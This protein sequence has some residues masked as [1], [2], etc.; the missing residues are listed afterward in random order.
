M[1]SKHTKEHQKCLY[2]PVKNHS[3][4]QCRY[5]PQRLSTS[6]SVKMLFFFR[7]NEDTYL[8]TCCYCTKTNRINLTSRGSGAE[9]S[10]T[11]AAG[12][13]DYCTLPNQAV[14]SKCCHFYPSKKRRVREGFQVASETMRRQQDDKISSFKFI[15]SSRSSGV[16]Q[17][18]V[19]K[20]LNT[21]QWSVWEAGIHA[22][23]H[24]LSTLQPLSDPRW[25]L[26][27]FI[28]PEPLFSSLMFSSEYGHVGSQ[29]CLCLTLVRKNTPKPNCLISTPC[30][31]SKWLQIISK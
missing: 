29:K 14:F 13:S 16:V 26:A 27:V 15:L 19:A 20:K 18:D 8:L 7:A 31:K 6:P 9:T 23:L 2:L 10:L 5:L 11:T 21:S 4:K 25:T 12:P 24:E 17:T 3:W 28:L 1:L 30:I 22:V